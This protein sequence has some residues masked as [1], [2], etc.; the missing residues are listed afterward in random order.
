MIELLKSK[1]DRAFN[2]ITGK[3]RSISSSK[4]VY[5][6]NKTPEKVST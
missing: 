6:V 4:Q 5:E 1:L 3:I 2:T